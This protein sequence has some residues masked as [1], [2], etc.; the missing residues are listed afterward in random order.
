LP[1]FEEVAGVCAVESLAGDHLLALG[2]LIL[3][4]DVEAGEG[5]VKRA[6]N[7]TR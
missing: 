5:G 2:N 7:R 1:G 4:G 6:E 3:D